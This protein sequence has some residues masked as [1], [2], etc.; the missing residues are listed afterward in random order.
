[1]IG[2]PLV[3]W[4]TWQHEWKR[5]FATLPWKSGILLTFALIAPW[6]YLAEKANPGFLQYFIIGEHIQRF[7]DPKWPDRY[8][9]GI[10][11]PMGS[12]IPLALIATLPWSAIAL[13]ELATKRGRAA[14]L[15]PAFRQDAWLR[16]LL[17]WVVMQLFFFSL[18][19]H[20]L[21]TYAAPAVPALALLIMHVLAQTWADKSRRTFAIIGMAAP[22]LMVI[23]A[24]VTGLMPA[25][26]FLPS[27]REV[28]ALKEKLAP[29]VPQPLVL[30]ARATVQ[31][32]L[33]C[34]NARRRRAG[35]GSARGTHREGRHVLRHRH[36]QRRLHPR[37]NPR[38]AQ[39]NR[40][41]E[42]FRHLPL[43]EE[44]RRAGGHSWRVRRRASWQR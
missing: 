8:G 36:A 26:G 40:P 43:G 5:A 42:R 14:I 41:F 34:Q 3:V 9:K 30:C 2:L 4:L 32:E 18:P 21:I 35:L 7:L 37:G 22:L 25:A 16:Y 15:A 10:I 44:D 38:A 6:Y 12:I 13:W 17:C 31:R 20:V 28:I 27:Q 19:R 39:G 33:L 23:A 29:G 1:M 11:V 24:F